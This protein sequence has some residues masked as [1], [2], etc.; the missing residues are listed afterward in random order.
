MVIDAHDYKGG[1][2][3]CLRLMAVMSPIAMS[4]DNVHLADDDGPL[5]TSI[6]CFSYC[7]AATVADDAEP[8][9]LPVSGVGATGT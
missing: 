2:W 5:P 8:A 1:D 9:R 3:P 6:R 7:C 4:S